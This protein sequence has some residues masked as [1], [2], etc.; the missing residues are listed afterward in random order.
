VNALR[1]LLLGE[2]WAL[3]LGVAMLALL[4]IAADTVGPNWWPG[5]GGPLLLM[6]ATLLVLASVWRSVRG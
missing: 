6:G 4:S 3:P 2:T 5:A 1:T